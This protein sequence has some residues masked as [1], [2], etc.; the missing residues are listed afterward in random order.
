MDL[1]FKSV[2]VPLTSKLN[3]GFVGRTEW[4]RPRDMEE[5]VLGLYVRPVTGRTDPVI[6]PGDPNVS[7]TTDRKGH[8]HHD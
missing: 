8:V 7:L 2:H 5:K 6:G 4:C 1:R 3:V